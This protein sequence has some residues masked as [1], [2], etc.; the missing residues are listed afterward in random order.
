MTSG[1]WNLKFV[2]A[3]ALLLLLG[4]HAQAQQP[5]LKES[6]DWLSSQLTSHASFSLGSGSTAYSQTFEPLSFNSCDLKWR[7]N[8]QNSWSNE[9]GIEEYSVDAGAIQTD[10]IVTINANSPRPWILELRAKDGFHYQDVTKV[11]AIE[12]RGKIDNPASIRFMFA[13]TDK[14]LL[15]RLTKAFTRAAELCRERKEPF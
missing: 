6:L 4:S 7:I 15:P 11:G 2:I 1:I 3:F 9:I 12:R 10:Q 14:D 13:E 8:H 5:T